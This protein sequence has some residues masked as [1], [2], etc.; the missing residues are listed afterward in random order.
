MKILVATGL[1]QGRRADDFNF[2]REGEIVGRDDAHTSDEELPE[3][4]CGC[5]RSLVGVETGRSTTTFQVIESGYTREEFE[6]IIR[7]ARSELLDAGVSDDNIRAEAELLL[8]I[9]ARFPAG[10][11]V[12]RRGD[13]YQARDV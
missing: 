1:T 5:Q 11:V 13:D 6:G 9:A 4:A 3:A 10:V 2:A 12:E 8:E 7:E